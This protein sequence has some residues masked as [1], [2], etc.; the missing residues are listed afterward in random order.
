MPYITPVGLMMT[1]KVETCRLFKH[2]H[3]VVC[4]FVT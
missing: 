4:C 2:L 1:Y 3:L